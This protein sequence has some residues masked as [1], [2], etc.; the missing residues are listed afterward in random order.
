MFVNFVTN[1]QKTGG[2]R[3]VV[4]P[5]DT[6]NR[7]EGTRKQRGNQKENGTKEDIY[8]KALKEIAEIC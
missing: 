1:K 8:I 3:N 6:E 2:K 5:V 7:V 4:L